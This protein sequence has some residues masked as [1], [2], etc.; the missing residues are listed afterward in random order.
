MANILSTAGVTDIRIL[1]AAA[2]H[3]T[4]EDTHTTVEEILRTF[5]VD[6]AKIVA[7]CTDDPSLS[8][9]EC[10]AAQIKSAPFKSPEAQ[11]VKLAE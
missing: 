8:G 10:K 11:Q 5:G 9:P 2:L 3:D 1:Q 6:V 7:E 4:V